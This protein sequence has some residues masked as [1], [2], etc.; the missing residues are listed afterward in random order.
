MGGDEI[1]ISEIWVRIEKL[2]N[3]IDNNNFLIYIYIY[4]MLMHLHPLF[5][6]STLTINI[7]IIAPKKSMNSIVLVYLF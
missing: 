6:I 2:M 5:S 4:G 3:K 1:E 7:I